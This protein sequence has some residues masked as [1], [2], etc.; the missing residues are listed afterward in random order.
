MPQ[1]I[2]T[3]ILRLP[4]YAV[5]AWE[6][7]EATSTLILA[8][9]QTAREPFY[10]CRGCGIGVRYVHSWT[11]R[12]LHDLPWGT[13]QVWLR[14]EVHRVDCPRCG[15]RTERLPFVTGKARATSRFESA[16]AQA[17]EQAP[18]SR[19]AAQWGLAPETVRRWDKRALQRWAAARP[20]RPLHYLGVDEFFVGKRVKFLTV[21]SDLI[22]GEPIWAGPECKRETLDRFFA[23]ALLPARR[24]GVWAVCVDMWEH[25][26]LQRVH[27]GTGLDEWADIEDTV[28]QV[29]ESLRGAIEQQLALC[30]VDEDREVLDLYA[31]DGR[32]LGWGRAKSSR[33][34]AWWAWSSP[35]PSPLPREGARWATTLRPPTP[36]SAK[37]RGLRRRP[38]MHGDERRGRDPRPVTRVARRATARRRRIRLPDRP[39]RRGRRRRCPGPPES[40]GRRGRRSPPPARATRRWEGRARAAR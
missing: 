29:P 12:R 10:V 1:E 27:E 16:V 22:R 18:V 23:K 6:A 9:R 20:R 2:V 34:R 26:E 14:V 13:W 38:S 8:I 31:P 17:C 15:V 19:V 5:Y 11:E 25:V 7:D 36:R 4:G 24:R 30:G 21:V 39:A 28:R 40:R 35:P 37:E 32:R 33:P 3:R